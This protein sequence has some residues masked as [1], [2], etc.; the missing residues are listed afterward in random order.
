MY[1]NYSAP[2]NLGGGGRMRQNTISF[3]SVLD[4]DYCTS[5]F[6][7]CL[8]AKTNG[9]DVCTPFSPRQNSR[10]HSHTNP[11]SNSQGFCNTLRHKQQWTI[12]DP[13]Y[14]WGMSHVFPRNHPWSEIASAS[15]LPSD[16]VGIE[17]EYQSMPRHWSIFNHT[18]NNKHSPNYFRA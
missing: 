2:R 7:Y 1:R 4:A 10:E 8:I 5:T 6:L 15:S 12:I 9:V 3:W 16:S 14:L 17:T 18:S 11:T 13:I